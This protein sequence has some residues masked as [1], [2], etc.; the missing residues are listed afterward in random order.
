MKSDG[1]IAIEGGGGGHHVRHDKDAVVHVAVGDSE[2]VVE[3]GY[4]FEASVF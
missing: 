1:G 2:K 4:P 3:I